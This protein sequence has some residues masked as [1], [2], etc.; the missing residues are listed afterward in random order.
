MS[1]SPATL[2]EGTW[3]A[4]E[5]PPDIRRRLGDI[6]EIATY[7]DGATLVVAGSPCP[8]MGVI[9]EGRVALRPAVPGLAPET[10]LTL[11]AGDIFGWSAVLSG[12]IATATA[13]AV[14]PVTA[15]LFDRQRLGLTL[16]NDC[17]LAAAVYRRVLAAVAR[18]LQVTRFQL[19]DL[20]RAGAE[21]W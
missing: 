14:A 12:S 20:Y 16:A 5:M 19:L 11:E 10:M 3:F 6:G 17:E 1:R 9:V 7:V 2:L 4:A 13:V 8:A 18:R 15:V 21:P